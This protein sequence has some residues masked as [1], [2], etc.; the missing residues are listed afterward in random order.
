MKTR[1]FASCAVALTLATAS[2]VADSVPFINGEGNN[3]AIGSFEG[4]ISYQSE[5]DND[6]GEF[7]GILSIEI[8]NTSDPGNGGFITALAFNI[9]RFSDPNP[10]GELLNSTDPDFHLISELDGN[11]DTNAPPL[12][13]G[14][15]I[16]ASVTDSWLGGGDP[17]KGIG[18]G[19]TATMT[20]RIRSDDVQSM[21]AMDFLTFDRSPWDDERTWHHNFVVR[22]RGFNDGRSDKLNGQPVPVPAP[23]AL[24]LAGLAGVVVMRR[25]AMKAG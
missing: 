4:E 6:L 20:F 22:M 16:G 19:D 17:S 3:G 18:V 15:D 13:N 7:V 1:L 9:P 8:T 12:G 24:G 25:R 23:V 5:F 14:Y 2:A 21:S 10:T 11:T